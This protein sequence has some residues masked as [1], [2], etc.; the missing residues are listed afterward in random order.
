MRIIIGADIAPTDSNKKLFQEGNV[1][2]LIGY[3][4]LELL[5]MAD[6]SC[7]NLEV[8]LTDQISPI[9]KFGPSL[10]AATNSVVGIKKMNP[11]FLTLANNHIMDQNVNG[12]VSTIKVLQENQIAFAGVGFIPEEASKPFVAQ[13]GNKRIGIYCCAE[14]EFSII[15]KDSPG[16]NPFDPLESLDHIQALKAETD[17]VIVLYHGG[18]ERYRYPSPRLQRVCRK[19]IEKGADLVVCQH[20][21]CVGCEEK[22]SGGTIVY[23]QGNFLFD[24]SKSEYWRTGLLIEL[25]LDEVVTIEYHPIVKKDNTVRIASR[26]EATEILS[27]FQNR[28]REILED[29]FIEKTFQSLADEMYFNYWGNIFA[30]TTKTLWFKALYKLTQGKIQEWVVQRKIDKRSILAMRN[31]LDCE[32]HQECFAQGLKERL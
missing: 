27:A 25:R 1:S 16:V 23:G 4:L 21:H 32:T 18:K 31:Y 14:H 28:S 11:S 7:F 24:N 26:E 29:G 6:F 20:S 15:R 10:S 30:K 8:P 2:E 12:L 9:D 5:Q 17:Y 3:E 22:W 13:V 19:I